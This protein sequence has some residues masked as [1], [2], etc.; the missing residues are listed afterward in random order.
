MTEKTIPKVSIELL[1][2]FKS[3][4]KHTETSIITVNEITDII[5]SENATSINKIKSYER[6]VLS[7][8][9]DNWKLTYYG[10]CTHTR[11]IKERYAK[12]K[13]TLDTWRTFLILLVVGAMRQNGWRTSDGRNRITLEKLNQ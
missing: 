2:E 6:K 12:N 1:E 11:S 5:K 4:I 10:A 8:T 9:I 13:N 3:Y 7:L